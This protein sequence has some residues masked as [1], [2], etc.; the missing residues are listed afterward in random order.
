MKIRKADRLDWQRV[1]TRRFAVKRID[2]PEYHG[3]ATLLHIDDVTEPLYATFNG[4]QV[5]IA[6]S[7][8]CNIFPMARIMSCWPL[9]MSAANWSSGISISS[10]RWAWMSAACPVMR[11][12][13][14]I[15]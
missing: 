2:T 4:Q 1:T 14:L 13:I 7:I 9:S 12:S 8:G 5:L 11:T 6:A 3:Y 15:L 10:D